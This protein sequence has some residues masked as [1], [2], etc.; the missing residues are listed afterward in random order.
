MVLEQMKI[1]DKPKIKHNPETVQGHH[2][3]ID[4][5]NL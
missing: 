4:F 3:Y 5:L 1:I 2:N